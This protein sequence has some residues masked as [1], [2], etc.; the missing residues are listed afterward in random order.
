MKIRKINS[1]GYTLVELL[2]V[3]AIM[4]LL[5]LFSF[6]AISMVTSAKGKDCATKIENVF[7]KTR[8]AAQ[9]RVG[10]HSVSIYLGDNNEVI[11]DSTDEG[12]II[13][14]R[15]GVRV[16]YQLSGSTEEYELG[17][18]DKKITFTYK[19]NSCSFTG[20]IYDNIKV[21]ANSHYW[22]IKFYKNT[23]KIEVTKYHIES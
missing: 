18:I 11:I 15:H 14:G 7:N 16:T 1:K 4:A 22:L 19:Q 10:E 8:V 3:I 12:Q 2:V 20:V 6:Y 23:G 13:A 5:A 9:T 21:Y 17:K